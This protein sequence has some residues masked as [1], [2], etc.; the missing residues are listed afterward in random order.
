MKWTLRVT[1]LP[2]FSRCHYIL[3]LPPSSDL[4][5]PYSLLSLGD[6]SRVSA[7][8]SN[9]SSAALTPSLWISPAIP[10]SLR[11]KQKAGHP[12]S[13]LILITQPCTWMSNSPGIS[14]PPGYMPWWLHSQP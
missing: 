1:L 13:R 2:G 7:R 5:V 3:I 12:G 10:P 6:F 11:F 9:S 14:E 4:Q 8:A